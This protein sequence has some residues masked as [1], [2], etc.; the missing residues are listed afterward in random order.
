MYIYIYIYICTQIWESS[1]LQKLFIYFVY[2]YLF[3]Y[4][5][6]PI[7]SIGITPLIRSIPRL[8][9]TALD[10]KGYCPYKNM[11]T[12]VCVYIYIYIYTLDL[13]DEIPSSD[14]TGYCPYKNMYTYMYIYI[15]IYTLDL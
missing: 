3:S 4:G 2:I 1:N 10:L 11:Y 6:S 15:Y 8:W 7:L 5:G 13:G 12:W 14:Q 9:V